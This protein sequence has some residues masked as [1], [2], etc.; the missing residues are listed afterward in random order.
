MPDRCASRNPL[1]VTNRHVE[2]GSRFSGNAKKNLV[3]S[4]D[5]PGSKFRP[6]PIMFGRFPSSPGPIGGTGGAV[7]GSA[8]VLSNQNQCLGE[9]LRFGGA[10]KYDRSFH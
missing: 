6:P 10:P 9:C 5:R 4:R 1:C 2:R 7:V 3:T 8:C